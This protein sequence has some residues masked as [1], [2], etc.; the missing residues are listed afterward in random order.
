MFFSCIVTADDDIKRG[1]E[2]D[3]ALL[4]A[5]FVE[6][7]MIAISSCAQTSLPQKRDDDFIELSEVLFYLVVDYPT[8]RSSE[9]RFC[10]F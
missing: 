7:E 1:A 10:I 5:D 9:F 3:E 6:L 4:L 8:A 2:G